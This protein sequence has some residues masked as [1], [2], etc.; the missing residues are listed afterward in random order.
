MP[1]EKVMERYTAKIERGDEDTGPKPESSS[2]KKIT[3]CSSGL[4]KQQPSSSDVVSSSSHSE[5]V[6]KPEVSSEGILQK[7]LLT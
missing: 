3:A 7:L 5:E 2:P 4:S 6:S 1:I